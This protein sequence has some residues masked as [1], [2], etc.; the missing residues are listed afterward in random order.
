MTNSIYNSYKGL[1]LSGQVNLKSDTIMVMLVSG[2]YNGGSTTAKR[3][4]ITTGDIGANEVRDSQSSYV[5]GGKA[6]SNKSIYIDNL[7]DEAIFDADDL[8]WATSTITASGA[9]LYKSGSPA[10]LITW[11]DFGANQSSSNGTFQIIWNSAGILA[12]DEA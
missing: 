1:A 10:Y 4:H 5:I 6:L 12:I 3:T 8:S 7:T 2:S 11:I 9:V